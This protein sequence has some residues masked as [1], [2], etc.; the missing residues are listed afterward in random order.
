MVVY[1]V[2]IFQ[3]LLASGTHLIAKMVVRDIEP[4]TLT[5]LRSVLAAVGLLVY[6]LVAKKRFQFHKADYKRILWLSLLAI[7]I[8]QFLFLAGMRYSTPANAAL[9]YGSTPAVVLVVSHF[10]GK[11]Q[12]TFRKSLGVGVAFLGIALIVF[13]HGID[14]HSGYTFG[15]LLFLFAVIAWGL[16]TVQ[17]RSLTIKYGAFPTS[18]ATMILGGVLFMPIGVFGVANFD[19]S[20]LTLTHWGGLLYLAIATSVLSYYLWYYALERIEASKVAIFT[21]IQPVLTTLFSVLLFGQEITAVFV[22]GGLLALAGV[23]ITQ[24]G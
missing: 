16:Y 1:F 23:I 10:L 15:N 6:Y 19:F 14:F 11:E 22:L 5:M 12:I 7:P 13:Q 9:L 21:N 3:Q 24:F 4:V 2:L 8:N 18:A 17:G 20:T